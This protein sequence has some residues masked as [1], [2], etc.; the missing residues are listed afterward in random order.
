MRMQERDTMKPVPN[1]P[2]TDADMLDYVRLAARL[3]AL[4]IDEAQA[5]RV[6]GHLGRTQAMARLL[7]AFG[8]T[9]HDE[10]A[11]VFCPAPF[12]PADPVASSSSMADAPGASA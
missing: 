12:P 1:P 2:F 10:I 7:A 6:A 3:Q 4:P 9:P 8:L 11:E 5:V